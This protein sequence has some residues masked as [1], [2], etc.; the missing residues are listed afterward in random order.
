MT[1]KFAMRQGLAMVV[2]VGIV[3]TFASAGSTS[4]ADVAAVARATSV[5]FKLDNAAITHAL[6][7][8][9]L[10]SLDSIDALVNT[11][12]ALEMDMKV[13]R[14]LLARTSASTASGRAGRSLLLQGLTALAASGDFMLRYGRALGS[15][16]S[17]SVWQVDRRG[18]FTGR[19]EELD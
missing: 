6:D 7:R 2:V 10:D 3:L 17:A 14:A 19:I 11:G 12:L 1:D 13:H 15:G 8:L 5:S 18:Y 16:A 4:N 9:N